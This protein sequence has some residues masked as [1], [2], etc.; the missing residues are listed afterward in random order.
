MGTVAGS[1]TGDHVLSDHAHPV[2]IQ[3]LECV[4]KIASSYL[5]CVY[6]SACVYMCVRGCECVHPDCAKHSSAAEAQSCQW[7]VKVGL[8]LFLAEGSRTITAA[9][10]LASFPWAKDVSRTSYCRTHWPESSKGNPP[11]LLLYRPPQHTP[12]FSE[13]LQFSRLTDDFQKLVSVWGQK[14]GQQNMLTHPGQIVTLAE[15]VLRS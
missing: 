9:P 14:K 6:I 5:W 1:A 11:Q 3:L 2:Q 12:G 4:Y 8:S 13:T 7:S 15:R 10:G